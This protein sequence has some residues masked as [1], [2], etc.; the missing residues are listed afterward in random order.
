MSLGLGLVSAG[1]LWQRTVMKR[2][3][4]RYADHAWPVIPGAV[5]I[6][7]RYECGPL[8]PTVGCHPALDQWRSLAATASDVDDWWTLRPFSVLLATGLRFDVIEVPASLGQ[9]VSHVT[10]GPVAVTP[11]GRWMF[12]V[13][14]GEGL[15]PELER[16]LDVVLHGCDSWVPAPPTRTPDGRIRWRVSPAATGWRLPDP[17]AVQQALLTWGRPQ[18][19]TPTFASTTLR[20]RRAA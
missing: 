11:T 18:W 20:S 19:R 7:D 5:L 17:Y 10:V 13:T 6:G 15:R 12:F 9:S 8:C 1:L 3:A 4:Q 14:P 16:R 2:S